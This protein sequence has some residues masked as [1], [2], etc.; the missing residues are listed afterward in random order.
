VT[1]DTL[2][3]LS[4]F[5]DLEALFE[6]ARDGRNYSLNALPEERLANLLVE[7]LA[8]VLVEAEDLIAQISAASSRRAQEQPTVIHSGTRAA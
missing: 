5:P 4:L 6:R 8:P 3:A 1:P 7:R 2:K